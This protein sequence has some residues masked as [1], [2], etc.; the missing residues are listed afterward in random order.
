MCTFCAGRKPEKGGGRDW[1][2]EEEEGKEKGRKERQMIWKEVSEKM[3]DTQGREEMGTVR[4]SVSKS[5]LGSESDRAIEEGRR[6][7]ER[8]SE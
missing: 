3:R 1:G 6:A 7:S 4:G 5:E 2:L 8:T